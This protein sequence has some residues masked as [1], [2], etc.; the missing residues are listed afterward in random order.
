MK[1]IVRVMIVEDDA[2]IA[3][4]LSDVVESL[5]YQVC[6]IVMTQAEAVASARASRPDLMIVDVGLRSGSG[7]GAMQAILKERVTPHIFVTGDRRNVLQLAPD[8]VI[9][10]KPFF[11]PDLIRAIEVATAA[12]AAN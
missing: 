9:L 4:L 8:A 7:V 2:I 3:L 10:E 12:A 1:A 11:I 5:G 6:D